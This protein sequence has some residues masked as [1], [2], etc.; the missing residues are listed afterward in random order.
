MSNYT[1]ELRKCLEEK[2]GLEMFNNALSS[3]PIFDE[4]YRNVLN[5]KIKDNF[6]FREIGIQ[7]YGKFCFMLRRKM[8]LIMSV[9]N[10]YYETES[11]NFNPLFNIDIT[12]TFEHEN[13]TNGKL[14]NINNGETTNVSRE[15]NSTTGENVGMSNDTPNQETT[16]DDIKNGRF[17]SSSS[18]DENKTSNT[19]ESNITSNSINT[20]NQ[21]LENNTL[22][23]YT[24]KTIGSSA[25]LPFSKAI[26]QYR[27]I[28]IN[29]D[30]MILNDLEDLFMQIW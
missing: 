4:N 24:K 21:D 2:V 12:E 25:G 18:Y 30:E 20:N 15:T 19:G 17:L 8:N 11:I 27:E 10:K 1:I 3:Y 16:K 23:T 29:I 22:E 6:Y 14:K 9:Y 28:L 26:M 7:P 5:N 13:K